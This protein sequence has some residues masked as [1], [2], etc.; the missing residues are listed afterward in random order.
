[1]ALDPGVALLGLV[2]LVVLAI[3]AWAG[4]KRFPLRIGM[5]NFFRRK[6]QVAIVV[7]GLLVGTAIISSSYVIQTT[8]DYGIR[9]AVFHQLD[10]IDEIVILTG[11][12]GGREPFNVSVYDGLNTSLSAGE[13]PDIAGLAPRYQV[14]GS[15]FDNTSQLLEPSATVIGFNA[16]LDLGT[17]VRPDG[18]RWNGA[19]LGPTDVIVN[20]AFVNDTEAKVGDLVLAFIGTSTRPTPLTVSDIVLDSGRGALNGGADL[21]VRLDTVQAVLG[22]PNQINVITVA[23]VGGVTQGYLRTDKADAE[24]TAHLP[25][26][27]GFSIS[28]V[29]SDGVD[30]ATQ[31]V[32]QISQIFLLL[33][34]FTIVAG[35]LLIVNIFVMLAE[36]RKGEMGVARALGMRRAHLVQSFVAEGLAYALLSAFVGT[37]AGLLLAD[38]ILWA[39]AIVFPTQLLGGVSFTLT[40]T[41]LDLIRGFAIGFLITIGTILLASWRVSKLNIVRAIRD[42]PEPVERRST[43]RQLALGV[44]L[45]V[46]GA[47]LTEEAFRRGD[48]LF[49]DLGPSGLAIGLAILTR[50][51]VSPRLA[52]SAAGIFLLGWLLY[53]NKPIN[54]TAADIPVFVAA[55]LLMVFG[56]ILLVMFN[57][58]VLVWVASHVGR[59]RTWRPVVRTAVAYPM[60]KKFRT[61]TTLA[62]I[63]LIMFTI[64][65]LS[66]IQSIIGSGITTTIV[67]QS[68]GYDLIA[69]SNPS[70]PKPTFWSTF[71]NASFA[72]QVSEVHGLSWANRVPVSTN[73][74]SPIA[75]HNASFYGVP[76]EWVNASIPLAFQELDANYSTAEAAWRAIEDNSS[77]AVVDGSVVP[78]GIAGGFGGGGFF[79]FTVKLGDSLY[80]ENATGATHHVK[81]IGILYEQFIPG[82]FVG[83]NTVASDFRVTVPPYGI[84]APIDFPSI[85][86][87]KV[88]PG[89]DANAVSHDLERTFLL[90]Q[91]VVIDLQTLVAQITSVISGIFSLLE[92][93]LALGLIVGIAGLGIITMRNVVERRTETGALRALGFRKSMVLKSFLL[94]LAFI[95]GTGIVIGD[96]LGVALSYDIFL[97]F[98]TDFGSFVIPWDRLILLSAI[99]FIG[100]VVATASPAIRAARMPPAEAL[101]SYE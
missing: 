76:Q 29:K 37:L 92:A 57:S 79:S 41:D 35:V 16:A 47:V 44:L 49:Q 74:A 25:P 43:R 62:T 68:G 18:S 73:P 48:V 66:G 91:M 77:L 78:G 42:I 75:V 82:L 54:P 64:A 88:K 86:Y 1:M 89:V 8:F 87:M 50:N 38:V 31:N 67:R 26:S 2:A 93:Y 58:E 45:A 94:E 36:E 69:E 59:G 97:K 6:T 55:G 60:N 27:G 20:Q 24:L 17:F 84:S 4:R 15:A 5:G 98:F 22:T 39:F 100:A 32:N 34:S 61:G 80:Y 51:L 33:G 46:G 52:F 40:W 65:T 81:I 56:A 13:M 10:L 9:S 101:R 95:S 23:N 96:I 3:V 70:I 72:S 85:V 83:W 71:D 11:A 53:P 19:G 28:N 30:S 99:A 12:S 90:Y 7:A 21:F 63:A 14:S